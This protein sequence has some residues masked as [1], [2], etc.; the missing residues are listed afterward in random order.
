MASGVEPTLETYT[1]FLVV[2]GRT[3]LADQESVEYKVRILEELF[4]NRNSN[5]LYNSLTAYL[6]SQKKNRPVSFPMLSGTRNRLT[7]F[8]KVTDGILLIFP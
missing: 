7:Y 5:W 2:S 4:Y 3:D 8:I 1:V 6:F